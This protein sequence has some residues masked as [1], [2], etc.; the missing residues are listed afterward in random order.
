MFINVN[1]Q[2]EHPSCTV[3]QGG[4]AEGHSAIAEPVSLTQL[5]ILE[6]LGI[7]SEMGGKEL[8]YAPNPPPQGLP[9]KIS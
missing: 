3:V 9:L 6:F 2:I 8:E 7:L 4:G 1:L 5:G